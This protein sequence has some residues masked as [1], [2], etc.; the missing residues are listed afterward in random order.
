MCLNHL[1]MCSCFSVNSIVFEL[2]KLKSLGASSKQSWSTKALLAC[3]G[4]IQYVHDVE[5]L[6]PLPKANNLLMSPVNNFL[7]YKLL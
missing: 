5:L 2:N 7:I 4:S 6:K 1:N 3:Q